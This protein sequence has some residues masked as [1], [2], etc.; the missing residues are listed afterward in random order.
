MIALLTR[1]LRLDEADDAAL[2][3][4]GFLNGDPL[5]IALDGC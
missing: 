5:F 4:G 1:E 3:I 2:A